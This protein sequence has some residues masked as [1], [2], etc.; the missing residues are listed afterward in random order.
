MAIQ[1][2]VTLLAEADHFADSP[3]EDLVAAQIVVLP[4]EDSMVVQAY[5]QRVASQELVLCPGP[6]RL[7]ASKTRRPTELPATSSA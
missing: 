5:S 2:V 4:P 7:P 3:Q 1:S 6:T